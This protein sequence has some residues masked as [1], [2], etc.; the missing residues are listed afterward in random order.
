MNSD[1]TKRALAECKQLTQEYKSMQLYMHG[2]HQDF[3]QLNNLSKLEAVSGGSAEAL[4]KM[5]GDL[6]YYK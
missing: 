3:L 2:V 6:E 4:T 1:D 5:E